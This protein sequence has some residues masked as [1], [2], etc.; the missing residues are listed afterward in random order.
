MVSVDPSLALR[1]G[2]GSCG[3]GLDLA[4][5]GEFGVKRLGSRSRQRLDGLPEYVQSLAT[6]ATG[7]TKPLADTV[8]SCYDYG[9]RLTLSPLAPIRGYDVYQ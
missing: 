8:P 3:I 6:S 7:D 9:T 1:A 4:M 5:I 2:I